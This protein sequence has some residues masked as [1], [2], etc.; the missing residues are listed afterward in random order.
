[1]SDS[2]QQTLSTAVLAILRPLVRVLLRNGI[3]YG[4]F[5]E[6]VKKTY[7]EVAFSEFAPDTGKQTIS[8]VSALTGL[9]RKEAR[10]INGLEQPDQRESEQRYNRAVRVLSGWVNDPEFHTA[11]GKPSDLPLEGEH[12]SFAALVKKYSGD[13]PTRS[14]LTVLLSASAI[15]KTGDG[16][17]LVKPVYVPGNDPADKLAILGTDTA[18]LIATIDNNIVNE[19]QGLRF[20]RKVSNARIG[21]DAL[22][23]FRKLSARKAQQLLEQLDTWLSRHESNSAEQDSEPGHYVSLGIYY[24]ESPQDEEHPS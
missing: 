7:V 17:R 21:S 22:P 5:A 3:A 1:M 14:M 10:R 6:L 19:A 4:S 12:R 9:T 13:V 8:R 16:I 15:E 18:E 2:I 11:E 20:Q 24:Y 23:G